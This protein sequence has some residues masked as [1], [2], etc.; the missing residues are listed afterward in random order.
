MT[1]YE[2]GD[3]VDVPFPFIDTGTSKRRP[4]LV[5]STAGFQGDS[6]ACILAM[7]T[8]AERSRWGN[9]LLLRFWAEAGLKKPSL[10]RWK[11]F[12]LDEILIAGCRGRLVE[13]D[14][15][16]ICQKLLEV[17]AGWDIR[18]GRDIREGQSPA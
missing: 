5:L 11:L 3:V 2:P 14:R 12:T 16:A 17:F 13:Q 15:A 18:E 4:A 8:S 10:V 6:G 9:D 7:I 1:G